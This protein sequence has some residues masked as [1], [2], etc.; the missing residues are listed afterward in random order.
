M[1]RWKPFLPFRGSTILETVVATV[2][3]VCSRAVLVV[4]YR[5]EDL[6]E[7]F[8]SESRV[9]IVLNPAWESGMF[10]SIKA[11]VAEIGTPRFFI[12]LGDMPFLA[13]EVFEALLR[14]PP[15][16]AVFPVH[17]G[18]RG[19]PVLFREAVKALV[20]SADP[21]AGRMREIAARGTV[22]EMEWADDSILRDIDTPG[23]YEG[24]DQS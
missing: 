10:S 20:L 21:A 4:G 2:L 14:Y 12:A 13:A 19:H 23:D 22:A 11:G 6:R 24:M 18:R 7:R 17:G 15:A 16:D 9:R 5:G 1:G 3:T 8:L